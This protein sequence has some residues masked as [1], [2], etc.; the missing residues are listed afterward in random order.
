MYQNA[1][2]L[3]INEEAFPHTSMLNSPGITERYS[4]IVLEIIFSFPDG[5]YEA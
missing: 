4:V 2:Q 1:E 3:C 5:L